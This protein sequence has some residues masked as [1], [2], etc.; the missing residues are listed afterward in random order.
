MQYLGLAALLGSVGLVL[1]TV[2]ARIG[3]RLDWLLEWLKGCFLLIL[4]A[5][6]VVLGLAAWELQQFRPIEEQGS[7]AVLELTEAAPQR[8]DATLV[9]NGVKRQLQLEGDTWE[10]QVQVLRWTGL[11]KALGLSDG[12]RLARLNGRYVALEKQRGRNAAIAGRL[13]GTPQWRD[14]WLWLD[15]LDNPQFVEADAFV[16]RYMPMAH[17]ARFA[18]DLGPGGVKPAALNPAALHALKPAG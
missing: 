18:I 2:M 10:L 15:G 5:L 3:W 8:Y 14:L 1:L 16:V 7:V 17:G 6:S 12:Y 4:L 9:A 11:G 13:Y